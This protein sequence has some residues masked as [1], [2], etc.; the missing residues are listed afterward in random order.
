MSSKTAD[1]KEGPGRPLSLAARMTLWYTLSAFALVLVASG[2][3][4]HALSDG[5]DH[6]DDDLLSQKLQNLPPG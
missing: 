4:Y 1:K 3:L 2:F 5:L 6:E